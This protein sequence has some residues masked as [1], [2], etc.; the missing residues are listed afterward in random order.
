MRPCVFENTGHLLVGR[1]VKAATQHAIGI[2]K[3][4]ARDI[5]CIAD[6]HDSKV[7]LRIMFYAGTPY[8]PFTLEEVTVVASGKGMGMSTLGSGGAQ[9]GIR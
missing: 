8:C 7:I 5:N 3:V 4:I 6:P 9:S 1:A 2:G